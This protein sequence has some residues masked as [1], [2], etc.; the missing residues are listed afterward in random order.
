[1]E[2][3]WAGRELEREFIRK[4]RQEEKINIIKERRESA[5]ALRTTKIQQIRDSH[6]ERILQRICWRAA[7]RPLFVVAHP[8]AFLLFVVVVNLP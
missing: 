2:E 6:N 4:C 3:Q 7:H 5:D 1:V 8:H